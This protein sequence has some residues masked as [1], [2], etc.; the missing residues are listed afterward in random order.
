MKITV[1]YADEH[2]QKEIPLTAEANCTVEL[3]IK[4]SGILTLFPEIQLGVTPVGVNSR[5]EKLDKALEA[6]DR[7]E[8][9]RPL[10]IDPMD[11]R[12]KKR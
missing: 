12:R 5:Q 7:V 3:A 10:L 4:R 9:Y 2:R 8:I 1:V 6:G 11:A